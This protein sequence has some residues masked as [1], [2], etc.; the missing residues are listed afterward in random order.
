MLA[1]SMT[2]RAMKRCLLVSL[3]LHAGIFAL[4]SLS[5]PD[6]PCLQVEQQVWLV[7]SVPAG[8]SNTT[9]PEPA[10]A[11]TGWSASPGRSEDRRPMLR[12]AAASHPLRLGPQTEHADEIQGPTAPAGPV[13]ESHNHGGSVA[14]C[15]PTTP[16]AGGG[17]HGPSAGT[18]PDMVE[19]LGSS[20]AAA[21]LHRVLPAYPPIARRFGKEGEVTLRLSIDA[22]GRL[23]RVEVLNDPGHGFAEA[24]VRAM[25]RS[26]YSP[27]TKDG[28]GISSR[29]LVKISFRL[30]P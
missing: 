23:E 22:N 26:S 30:H 3:T 6:T 27:A 29:A 4:V 28:V 15:Q 9:S 10:A 16:L 13:D 21:F 18:P 8:M 17:T 7:E 14:A 25:E 24:A 19:Q 1:F 11:T 5:T 20:G 12:P 2:D